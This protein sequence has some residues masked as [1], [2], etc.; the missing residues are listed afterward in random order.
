MTINANYKSGIRRQG[1]RAQPVCAGSPA[2]TRVPRT[3]TYARTCLFESRVKRLE[4][5]ALR[6][7]VPSGEHALVIQSTAVTFIGLGI[8]ELIVLPL[9]EQGA[10]EQS[11]AI[12]PLETDIVL[13]IEV[14]R[15]GAQ[16]AGTRDINFLEG[17]SV[18]GGHH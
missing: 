15:S 16:W 10:M 14:Q 18:V 2:K 12:E 17:L 7:N 4:S 1:T 11:S 13:V 3:P 6:R 5:R 8:V 9:V